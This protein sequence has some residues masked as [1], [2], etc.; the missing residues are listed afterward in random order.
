[1]ILIIKS[2]KPFVD[3]LEVWEIFLDISKA[4]DKIY[5]EGL[6]FKLNRNGISGKR[7]EFLRDFLYC[8]KQ[9]IALN[10]QHSSWY[11][12]KPGGLQ[13]SVLEPLFF[14]YLFKQIIEGLS[15]NCKLFADDTSFSSI[16]NTKTSVTTLSNDMTAIGNDFQSWFN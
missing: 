15:W 11:N 6:L 2:H 4:F 9:R 10:R 8:P 5:H 1:M 14:S 13:V 3:G 12:V 16:V 7:L